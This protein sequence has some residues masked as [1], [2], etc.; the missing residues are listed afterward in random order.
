MKSLTDD[1]HIFYETTRVW[2]KN[3][4]MGIPV[5]RFPC[6]MMVQQELIYRIKPDYIIET[7]TGLGGGA[8]FFATVCEIIEHGK[9]ITIDLTH[10]YNSDL[11]PKKV[12]DR[13]IFLGGGST[14]PLLFEEVKKLANGKKNMVFLDSWH[15]KE[16]V[17]EEMELYSPLVSF[18]SYMVVEDTHAGKIGHPVQWKYDTFGAYEAVEEFLKTHNEFE[19]DY[20]CEKHLMTFHPRGWLKKIKV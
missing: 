11:I 6:D 8:A 14:N 2:E 15:V 13:I 18:G 16:Y 9:V 20:E 17:L 19:V 1:F 5:W 10:R 4:W 7:G 12:R 3:L